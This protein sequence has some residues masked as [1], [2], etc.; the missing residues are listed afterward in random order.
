VPMLFMGEEWG[1]RRPFPFFCDFR[2]GLAEA[3]RAGRRKEFAEAYGRHGDG[4][5][6][7]VEEATLCNAVLDW[8]SCASA[9]GKQRLEFVR[10]LLAVRRQEI[11]PR[12]AGAKFGTAQA[13]AGLLTAHWRMGDGAKLKLTANLGDR[14]VKATDPGGTL[15]WGDDVTESL[16]PWM[17]SWHIE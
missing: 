16:P 14:R 13:A 3:V 1:S 11:V 7:P 15:I 17:V 2:G 12:L 5:P 6:D 8:D 4:I 9:P 10:H